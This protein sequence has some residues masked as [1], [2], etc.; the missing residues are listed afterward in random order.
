MDGLEERGTRA[1]HE[2]T[3]FE[4]RRVHVEGRGATASTH[5]VDEARTAPVPPRRSTET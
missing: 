1:P 2:T 3:L 4:L 5:V